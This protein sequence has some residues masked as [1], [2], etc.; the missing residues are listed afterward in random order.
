MK[1]NTDFS[2][3]KFKKTHINKLAIIGDL[4]VNSNIYC[5][6]GFKDYVFKLP[7]D[8]MLDPYSNR[9]WVWSLQQ[10]SFIQPL[11]AYD[12]Y[13][14]KAGCNQG[15]YLALDLITSWFENFKNSEKKEPEWHDHGTALRL[16][17]IL[18]CYCRIDEIILKKE[19]EENEITTLLGKQKYLLNAIQLHV[20]T[21]AEDSFYSKGTNH[22]L[23]QS[24]V[25]FEVSEIF[26]KTKGFISFVELA[27]IRILFEIDN[28]FAEDGGHVENSPGYLN[29]GL[30][31]LMSIISL[32]QV[33]DKGDRGIEH[34]QQLLN[35]IT[36][37]LTFVTKPNGKLPLIGDTADFVVK[38]IFNDEIK[39]KEEIYLQF[40]YLIKKGLEGV[41]P[42][43]N[44]LILQDSGY[45]IFRN[46][47]GNSKSFDK[48]F[49]LVFKSGFL[50]NYHRHDDD[51]SF[52]V[53]YDGE[54]WL[55]DGG[56][57]KHEPNDPYR[58]YFRSAESHNISMPYAVRAHR[59]LDESKKTGITKYVTNGQTSTVQ[60]QSFMFKGFENK[61]ELSFCR[62]SCT[63]NIHD[64]CIP[65]NTNA[66]DRISDRGGK[67]WTTYV[68]RFM[69]PNDKKIDINK[70]LG[71]IKVIG[72]SK[73]MKIK[74][75]NFNGNILLISGQEEPSVRGWVSIK[76][77]V[78][79]KAYSLELHHSDERLN[80]YYSIS[81]EELKKCSIK[82]TALVKNNKAYAST[83]IE[84][85]SSLDGPTFAFY[86][87]YNNEKVLQRW[88]E[89]SN[90][91]IFDLDG[92]LELKN[93]SV[94]GFVRDKN[95]HK[96]QKKITLNDDL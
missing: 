16:K 50:S 80:F 27:K 77:G 11:I 75:S 45:A 28:A 67:S 90:E 65:V 49:H 82:V 72:N 89:N 18:F 38:D 63:I 25:L 40:K 35:K 15:L 44:S 4:F 26:L 12:I 54:D 85:M 57:Y 39:P 53:Y 64:S 83:H 60:A 62:Q 70:K 93:Y 55:I 96:I 43:N 21:L 87:M 9:T 92:D 8:W 47:W 95:G 41:C 17:N 52:V 31:Q 74:L 32:W 73:V 36:L 22:G 7:F 6:N 61:R 14:N 86:L 69:I 30:Q 33:Y 29:F 20:N 58:I 1:I 81:F 76:S 56:L 51:L 37:A 68:T 88:Y 13:E 66:I 59:N 78:L 10:L 34:L 46:H 48:A 71:E 19:I 23:D 91:I 24:L 94:I 79:E 5:V 42:P 3:K 84:G 2:Y